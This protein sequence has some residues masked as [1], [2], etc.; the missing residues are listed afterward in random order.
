MDDQDQKKAI[1][2]KLSPR[3]KKFIDKIGYENWE[4]FQEP[5]H[6]IDT[7]EDPTKRNAQQLLSE[8]FQ[9]K[10]ELRNTSYGT[11]VQEICMGIFTTSNDKYKGMFDFCIWYYQELKKQD[12]DID[13]I[14]EK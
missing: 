12:I 5:K 13:K 14:W 8:F 6:P 11:G 3:R 1:Y 9:E 4:P 2:D 10:E 7:R